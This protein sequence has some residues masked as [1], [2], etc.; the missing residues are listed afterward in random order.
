MRKPLRTDGSIG[1]KP[2]SKLFTFFPGLAR[3]KPSAKLVLAQAPRPRCKKGCYDV[4]SSWN[5]AVNGRDALGGYLTEW[6]IAAQL[7]AIISSR[8]HRHSHLGS[9]TSGT[10]S[11][12]EH[13]HPAP[14]L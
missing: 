9:R 12:A 7:C 13:L 4:G 5:L 10:R 11:A 8:C 14:V 2:M 3:S 6:D 1:I